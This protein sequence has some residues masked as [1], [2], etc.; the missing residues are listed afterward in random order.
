MWRLSYLP[1]NIRDFA[2]K[3]CNNL[4]LFNAQLAKFSD[5]SPACTQC[6]IAVNF[7]TPK[8]TYVHFYLYCSPNTDLISIQYFNIF[9]SQ[10]NI[11]WV[12]D[13]VFLGAPSNTPFYKALVINT[14]IILSSWFLFECRNKKVKPTLGMLNDFIKNYRAIFLRFPKYQNAY[15]KWIR[16]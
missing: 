1:M 14:E 6:T 7:P 8:E 11:A 13:F 10:S 3:F 9:L 4:L 5:T 12:A 16:E 15:T 2:F